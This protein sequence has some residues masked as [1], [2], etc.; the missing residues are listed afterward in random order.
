MIQA[1]IIKLLI[2]RGI[3]ALSELLGKAIRHGAT[4]YGGAMIAHG[5]ASGDDVTQLQGAGLILVGIGLSA[6]RTFLAKY[7]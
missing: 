4:T 7:A 1:F 6:L 5:Y 2:G 3:G